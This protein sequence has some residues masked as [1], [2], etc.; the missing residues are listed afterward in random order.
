MEYIG[1]CGSL[2]TQRAERL[3]TSA[4]PPEMLKSPAPGIIL[5]AK[6]KAN[7]HLQLSVDLTVLILYFLKVA[8]E[9]FS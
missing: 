5:R 6:L 2:V 9:E 8:P 4:E 3:W 7:E 1:I